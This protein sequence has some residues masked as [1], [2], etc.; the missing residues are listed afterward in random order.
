MNGSLARTCPLMRN[1]AWQSPSYAAKASH[2]FLKQL[3]HAL[4][5]RGQNLRIALVAARKKFRSTT[6]K[7]LL[8][9]VASAKRGVCAD[10]SRAEKVISDE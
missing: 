2:L 3:Y 4:F 6:A 7:T 8:D 9:F 1:S 5:R 10:V